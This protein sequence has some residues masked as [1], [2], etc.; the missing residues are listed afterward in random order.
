MKVIQYFNLDQV[1]TSQSTYP[2]FRYAGNEGA[3]VVD[4]N[5]L[6][7]FE[8]DGEIEDGNWI[9]DLTTDTLVRP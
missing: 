3:V 7:R 8:V 6:L 2:L 5:L 1:K 4:K 9:L